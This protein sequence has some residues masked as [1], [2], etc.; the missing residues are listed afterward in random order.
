MRIIYFLSGISLC[1]G[2]YSNY[3]LCVYTLLGRGLSLIIER[4]SAMLFLMGAYSPIA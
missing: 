1:T 2:N 4:T 3:T